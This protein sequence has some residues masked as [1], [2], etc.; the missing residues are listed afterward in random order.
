MPRTNEKADLS[1]GP[2]I[3]VGY[4]AKLAH[5]GISAEEEAVFGRQLGAVLAYMAQLSELNLEGIEPTSHGLPAS[6][7]FRD[8]QLQPGL[9]RE[10]ALANAPL[11]TMTEFMVPKIVE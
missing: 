3:D 10:A 4:V 11:R 9:D 7:I 8:D 2:D 5:I 6:N 1:G